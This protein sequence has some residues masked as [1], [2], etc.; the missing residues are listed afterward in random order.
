MRF[1][2]PKSRKKKRNRNIVTLPA[3][4]T[5]PDASRLDKIKFPATLKTDTVGPALDRK[6]AAHLAVT[7]PK[8]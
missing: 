4:D 1:T 2:K 7:T 5:S 6:Y 8:H 3:G